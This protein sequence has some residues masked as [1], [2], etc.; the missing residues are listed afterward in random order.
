MGELRDALVTLEQVLAEVGAPVV[1]HLRPGAAPEAVRDA[2]VASGA[3]P[4]PDL[5]SWYGWHDGTDL[6]RSTTRQLLPTDGNRLIGGLHLLALEE[7][8]A[9]HDEARALEEESADPRRG[10]PLFLWPGWFPVLT[11]TDG[12]LVCLDTAGTC[13]HVGSLFVWDTGALAWP[14]PPQPWLGSLGDLVTAVIDAYRSGRV[15]PTQLVIGD[16]LPES[17]RTLLY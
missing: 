2:V 10:R 3:E 11:F 6:P 8:R 13:G 12:W 7:A 15:S 1:G 16:D 9:G 5:L 17:A 14:E 4:H